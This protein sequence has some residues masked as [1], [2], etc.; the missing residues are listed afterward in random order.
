MG[1]EVG[2]LPGETFFFLSPEIS[3]TLTVWSREAETMR[4]SDG[5][6]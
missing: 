1:E 6:N 4:S 2:E 3:Q 5:W